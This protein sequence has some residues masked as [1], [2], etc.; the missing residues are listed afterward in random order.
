MTE[1]LDLEHD[2]QRLSFFQLFR[3]SDLKIEIPIIQRDYA[4]GRQKEAVVRDTFL[5]ALFG[6]LESNRPFNDLD[7]VYGSITES[8]KFIPL[9]GQQRLTTL[10]LLHWYLAVSAGERE[11][12]NVILSHNQQARFTYETRSSSREFCDALVTSSFDYSQIADCGSADAVSAIIKDQHWF[13]TSW[14]LDPT[15]QSMLTMLDAIH[16]KF[17]GHP[18]FYLRLTHDESP[19]ITFRFLNLEKFLLT[20]DL[21]IKMNARGKPLTTFENFKAKLEKKIQSFQGDWPTHY[22]LPRKPLPVSGYDYFIYKIDNEWADVFWPFRNTDSDDNTFDDELMNFIGLFIAQHQLLQS[23]TSVYEAQQTFFDGAEVKVL[24][25]QE[26]ENANALSQGQLIKLIEHLD[27]LSAD[28]TQE[29][30]TQYL[31]NADYY[32]EIETFKKVL[33]NSTSYPEKLRFFAFYSAIANGKRDQ[34]LVEWMRV[35]FNLTEHKIFNTFS[36]YHASL[37]SLNELASHRAPILDLLRNDIDIKAFPEYQVFEEKLKAHLLL[38]SNEWRTRILQIEH[39]PYLKGQIGFVLK[40]SGVVDYFIANQDVE[41]SDN[42]EVLSQFTHYAKAAESIFD[43]LIDGSENMNYAWERAVLCKGTYFINTGGN[44]YNVLSSLRGKNARRDFSW[45][46]L[47]RLSLASDDEWNQKQTYVQ[48]VFDDP[49]FSTGNVLESLE[50]ICSASVSTQDFNQQNWQHLLI[51]TPS[52]FHI[53]EQGFVMLE[54]DTVILMHQSQ[55]NHYQSEIKTAFLYRELAEESFDFTPFSLLPYDS[56]RGMDSRPGLKFAS[57][58]K[59]EVYYLYVSYSNSSFRL[60]I[61]KNSGDEEAISDEIKIALYEFGFLED[62]FFGDLLNQLEFE[63]SDMSS[64]KAM[65]YQVCNCFKG[66]TN[67]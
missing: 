2:G 62:E 43:L 61:S 58:Q 20:D 26:Y 16:L 7:F 57:F 14:C 17:S 38:K 56:Q 15:I 5:Q 50:A 65:V 52:L 29:G 34:E 4:Q 54:E 35:V 6:Y 23:G 64:A 18:E 66:L 47:L 19:V 24:S 45:S 13:F 37:V 25:L 33:A 48:Q 59:G 51:T 44:K 12:F 3:D 60:T 1:P 21:Y 42:E 9:D 22:S 32:R 40:F 8:S 36:D 63:C 53:T 39:H 55:R 49:L 27:L 11:S 30:I 31:V 67:D 28:R 41:W 10:F 46:R